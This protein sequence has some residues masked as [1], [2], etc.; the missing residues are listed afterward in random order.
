MIN[1]YTFFKELIDS[2]VPEKQ[3]EVLAKYINNKDTFVSK[4]QIHSIEQEQFD[5]KTD[6]AVIDMADVK[7]DIAEVKTDLRW[8]KAILIALLALAIKNTFFMGN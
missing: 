2:G 7:S 6:L 1:A 5:I 3:A 8:I 4:E